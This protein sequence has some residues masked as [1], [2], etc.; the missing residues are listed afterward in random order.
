[1]LRH[2]IYIL[3]DTLLTTH[4]AKERDIDLP[5]KKLLLSAFMCFLS[6]ARLMQRQ[7]QTTF[8]INSETR[9]LFLV[10]LL[11]HAYLDAL[12]SCPH[13]HGRDIM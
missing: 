2:S 3:K 11:P 10:L 8:K 1:M 13:C 9:S 4:S 5:P 12:H 7:G 6:F